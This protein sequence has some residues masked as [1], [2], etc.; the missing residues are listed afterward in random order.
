MNALHSRI[1]AAAMLL[2][3]GFLSAC[4]SDKQ[5]DNLEGPIGPGAGG[6]PI[7]TP[8][9]QQ[10]NK[11]DNSILGTMSYDT[12]FFTPSVTAPTPP[13]S[14]TGVGNGVAITL[15]HI[16]GRPDTPCRFN[17]AVL[18]RDQG[19]DIGDT[20]FRSNASGQELYQVNVS[21]AGSWVRLFCVNLRDNAGMQFA[22]SSDAPDKVGWVQVHYVLNSIHP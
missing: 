11:P 9:P 22:V 19:Y 15:T 20:G 7:A 14:L 5:K 18:A 16:S 10:L 21:K 2:A 4:G 1:A 12:V 3:L 17:A 13:D 8:L 6:P